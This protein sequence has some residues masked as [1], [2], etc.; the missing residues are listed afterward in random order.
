MPLRP[1]RL[2]PIVVLLACGHAPPAPPA[3][4]AEP[5][6]AAAPAPPAPETPAEPTGPTTEPA[7]PVAAT[8]GQPG[9]Q[10]VTFDDDNDPEPTT[11][12]Q[13]Q[14]KRPPIPRFKLF[15]TRET[16]GPK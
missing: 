4:P 9:A 1:A 5:V 16:D 2:L 8:P 7:E 14:P 10:Q 12:V 11:M 15:G 3:A 13:T 6:A